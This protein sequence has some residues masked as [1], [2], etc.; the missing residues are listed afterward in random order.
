MLLQIYEPGQTPLPHSEDVAVGIDL[1][2]TNSL[3]AISHDEI[4]EVICDENGNF[5][6]DSRLGNLYSVKR[7]MGL[8]KNEA[9]DIIKNF[10]F[11]I[12]EENSDKIIRLIDNNKEIT[13]IEFSA[14]IL[15]KLKEKAETAI[16]KKVEKAVITVPAYFN[17]SQRLATKDAAKLAGIEVLRLLNEPTA[18]ALAY[19]LDKKVEGIYAIYDLGGGTFDVSIL[20]M[21]MGVFKVVATGGDTLLGGDDFDFA[22]AVLIKK[23]LSLG[24]E[25]PISD[26]KEV[27]KKAKESLSF[28]EDAKILFKNYNEIIIS[29][30]EFENLISDMVDKTIK[31]FEDV[32]K[33]SK[34][35][36]KKINGV[37]LVGG[38]TRVPLVRNKIENLTGKKPLIDID[39]DK[40]VALGASIQAEALTRG[41]NNLLL[42]VTPL[43][44][45]LETYGGLMEVLIQR[46]TPIPAKASQKFTTFEDGQTAM[47]FHILQGEREMAENCRSLAKFELKGIPSALAGIPVVNVN[48]SI[49]A[50][51]ILTVSAIE[52][53]S[54]SK[55]E[56]EVKPSYGLDA[57]EMEKM[58]LSSMQQAKA[59]IM[60][61]LLQESRI[62]AEIAIKT[63]ESALKNDSY[64]ISDEY[65]NK[66]LEQI[67]KIKEISKSDERE[68]IDLEVKSLDA[69]ATDFADARTNK[70]LQGYL[71]GKRIGNFS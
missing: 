22:L 23:K 55:A 63:I 9:K 21:Q 53:T 10:G 58:L 37:V 7:L 31:I 70:A 20:K 39:P 35:E 38:S 52:E 36:P 69:M 66:I 33:D 6:T 16:G 15:K 30:A 47:K 59:D 19:G 71:K 8:G 44:L 68:L 25:V 29:K 24:V 61:R 41:S 27:A 54:N 12:N 28:A 17:E 3:V 57:E 64:L 18:A 60:A 43:S 11:K 5:I 40:V 62:E 14:E 56:I 13:P 50:D 26:L 65:K 48:F 49:D 46:N 4:A 45:G 42:D 2:T 51:G 1:G 32:I 67:K 34:I